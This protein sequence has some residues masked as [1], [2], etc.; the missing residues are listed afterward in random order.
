MSKQFDFSGIIINFYCG[1]Q[2]HQF[3]ELT[4]C[5]GNQI[6]LSVREFNK[7]F[8]NRAVDAELIRRLTIENKKGA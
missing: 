8:N 4:G 6:T 1:P 7:A 5:S 2:G 3:V